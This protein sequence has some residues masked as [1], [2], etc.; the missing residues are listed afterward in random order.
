MKT[1]GMYGAEPDY[2]DESK[3]SLMTTSLTEGWGKD[4]MELLIN[5]LRGGSFSRGKETALGGESTK[6]TSRIFQNYHI[7][8]DDCNTTMG[9]ITKI[10]DVNYKNYVGRYVVGSDKPLT[11]E[12][13]KAMRDSG[14]TI[15]L[16]SPAW[17]SYPGTSFCKRCFGHGVADNGLGLNS[18]AII[19]TS[20]MMYIS[21]KAM[22]SRQLSVGKYN[23]KD[24]IG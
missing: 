22:H 6:I 3:L 8:V 16:R 15:K 1:M 17:C 11:I 20:A 5:N 12:E 10:N 19:A 9:L 7:D 21:M 24:R 13:L 18:Q 23:F 14:K 2:Y 4:N